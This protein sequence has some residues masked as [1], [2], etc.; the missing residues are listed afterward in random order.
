MEKTRIRV[1]DFVP[2]DLIVSAKTE[3]LSAKAFMSAA[4]RQQSYREM[5]IIY[6]LEDALPDT[7]GWGEEAKNFS[8]MVTEFLATN[9]NHKIVICVGD[10]NLVK[11]LEQELLQLNKDRIE[12]GCQS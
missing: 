1:T 12:E 6:D 3:L 7:N 4:V 5:L 10:N 9:P 11:L 8:E 2:M